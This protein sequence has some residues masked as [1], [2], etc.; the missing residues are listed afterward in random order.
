MN[1]SRLVCLFI[2]VLYLG[3]RCVYGCMVKFRMVFFRRVHRAPSCEKMMV[4][5]N[6][7]TT[8]IKKCRV[9]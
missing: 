1:G 3:V 8:P 5:V 4:H 9:I 2:Y 7:I 6:W